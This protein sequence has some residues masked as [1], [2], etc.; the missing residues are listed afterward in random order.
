MGQF[1]K[2]S[3][4]VE[5]VTDHIQKLIGLSLLREAT[6]VLLYLS[7]YLH[8]TG[9]TYDIVSVYSNLSELLEQ[10][11]K[12]LAAND[13]IKDSLLTKTAAKTALFIALRGKVQ[14]PPAT[15]LFEDIDQLVQ[16]IEDST[17]ILFSMIADAKPPQSL[18]ER[19]HER[20]HVEKHPPLAEKDVSVQDRSD[21]SG[22]AK[23][24]HARE[25]FAQ[26]SG[27]EM[28]LDSTGN[29]LIESDG[30]VYIHKP[31]ERTYVQLSQEAVYVQSP[32]GTVYVQT[33]QEAVY[34]QAPEQTTYV[35]IPRETV[36]VQHPEQVTY[37]QDP[38]DTVY[39]QEPQ[40]VTYVQSP[41]ETV[42][43]QR[44]DQVTYVQEPQDTVYVQEP[45]QI[46]YVQQ[47]RE[48]VYVQEPKE[49]VRIYEPEGDVHIYASKGQ[50]HLYE[51][52]EIHIHKSN[53]DINVYEHDAHVDKNPDLQHTHDDLEE[54]EPLP[55][56]TADY[57]IPETIAINLRQKLYDMGVIK[58]M[59]PLLTREYF[60]R[61]TDRLAGI[62]EKLPDPPEYT[63][64]TSSDE[65]GYENQGVLENLSALEIR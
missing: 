24:E 63:G 16:D 29:Y 39:V 49:Q 60:C 59:C 40:Q 34:V 42:Y 55:L 2:P 33:P 20:W 36:Y 25:K 12:T 35:Q 26:S 61:V 48:A 38:K 5:F 54:Q 58:S 11:S 22:A 37:V 46:T 9:Q 13:E 52:A 50:V 41:K 21:V 15:G 3:D 53:Q 30:P 64:P 4:V 51:P 45:A 1:R 23:V 6:E 28:V 43:V 57:K 8:N 27:R 7:I 32:R 19:L 17:N 18:I 56:Y 62:V 31:K 10:H 44:P 65:M 47:P 14:S